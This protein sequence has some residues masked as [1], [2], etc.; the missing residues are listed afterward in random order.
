MLYVYVCVWKDV[1]NQQG[2][3]FPACLGG[4]L[5]GG[6]VMRGKSNMVSDAQNS[7]QCLSHINVGGGV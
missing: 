2:A 1:N 5:G 4:W 6:D 3:D 7:H